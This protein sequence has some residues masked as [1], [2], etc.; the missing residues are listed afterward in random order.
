MASVRLHAKKEMPEMF[1]LFL[2]Q[3]KDQRRRI[4]EQGN[5]RVIDGGHDPEARPS[6]IQ[7]SIV[8]TPKLVQTTV[9]LNVPLC[10]FA[11]RL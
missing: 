5:P 8:S 9:L 6:R 4:N 3:E 7:L 2:T 11:R 1:V 10:V